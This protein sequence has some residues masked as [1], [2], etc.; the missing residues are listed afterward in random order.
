MLIAWWYED[1]P[2]SINISEDDCPLINREC[3]TRPAFE[4]EKEMYKNCISVYKICNDG[5]IKLYK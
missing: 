3:G 4:F 1:R 2:W 5:T